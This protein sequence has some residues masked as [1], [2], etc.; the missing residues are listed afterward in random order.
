[1]TVCVN[2]IPQVRFIYYCNVK[3]WDETETLLLIKNREELC[4][5]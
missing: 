3:I 4:K 2:I 5:G 1:M